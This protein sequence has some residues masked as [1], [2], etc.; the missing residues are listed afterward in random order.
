MRLDFGNTEDSLELNEY[1]ILFK[2][3]TGETAMLWRLCV[4][5]GVHLLAAWG[6]VDGKESYAR[7][8]RSWLMPGTL[9]CGTGSA[10][11]NFTSLGVFHGA[12]LCCREHDHCTPQIQSFEFRYGWR[13]YLLYTVSHCDCDHRFRMCLHAIN[14]TISTLVGKVYFNIFQAPCFT[15]KDEEQCTDWH[16]WGG[17]KK[18]GLVPKAEVQKQAPFNYITN[19]V[20]TARFIQGEAQTRIKSRSALTSKRG[21][22]KAPVISYNVTDFYTP[23][24]YNG[25]Y[26]STSYSQDPNT[27]KD[28]HSTLLKL[29]SKQGKTERDNKHVQL[30]NTTKERVRNLSKEGGPGNFLMKQKMKQMRQ[31]ETKGNSGKE[32]VWNLLKEGRQIRLLRKKSKLLRQTETKGDKD[33]QARESAKTVRILSKVYLEREPTKDSKQMSDTF[34]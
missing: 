24:P 18:Y 5:M 2:A 20:T 34:S 3:L 7:Y 30:Y 11:E 14:D 16:W 28:K 10:A 29:Q 6:G 13:N 32:R 8:K 26:P 33:P 9:W 21:R 23:F 15:L 12:D 25:K 17:C 19:S 27:N 4:L 31:A 1:S 22:A